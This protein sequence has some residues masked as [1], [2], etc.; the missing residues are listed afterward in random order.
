MIINGKDL[1]TMGTEELREFAM[2]EQARADE[3]L[4]N[5]AAIRA[6]MG[7]PG[8]WVEFMLDTQAELKAKYGS[9]L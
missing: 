1:N 7:K 3:A 9:T 4:A 8:S 6:A 2:A 5:V